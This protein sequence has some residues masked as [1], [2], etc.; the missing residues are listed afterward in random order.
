[1]NGRKDTSNLFSLP[2]VFCVKFSKISKSTNLPLADL[3]C[4]FYGWSWTQTE[5]NVSDF[6][7][8]VRTCELKGPG[9]QLRFPRSSCCGVFRGVGEPLSISSGSRTWA[10]CVMIL[11]YSKI[12]WADQALDPGERVRRTHCCGKQA[13]VCRSHWKP[14]WILVFRCP[15]KRAVCP[16]G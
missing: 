15:R 4:L 14:V 16:E 6:L 11:Y 8:G 10:D 7:T 12:W 13:R 5:N 2:M 3:R 1:M 9:I